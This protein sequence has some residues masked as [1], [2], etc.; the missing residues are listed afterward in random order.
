[1]NP[2]DFG[3]GDLYAAWVFMAVTFGGGFGLGAPLARFNRASA[4]RSDELF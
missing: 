3:R 4:K 2:E 1:M